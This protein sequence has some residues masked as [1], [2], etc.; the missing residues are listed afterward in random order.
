MKNAIFNK[1]AALFIEYALLVA[2][3][4]AAF[5]AMAGYIKGSVCGTWKRNADSFGY[6]LQYEPGVTEVEVITE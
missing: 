2:I 4:V 5:I 6:G 3:V 1:R